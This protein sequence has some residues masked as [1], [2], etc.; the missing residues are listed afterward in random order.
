[1]SRIV[2][3]LAVAALLLLLVGLAIAWLGGAFHEKVDDAAG[4][5]R[6]A[7]APRAVGAAVLSDVRLLRVPRVEQAVGS[8][9]AVHETD[10]ASRVLAAVLEIV[11]RAGDAVERGAVVARLDDDALRAR[12]R[13]AE[14][15]LDS[16]RAVLERARTEADRL[17]VLIERGAV[18]KSERDDAETA[19]RTTQAAAERA[20]RALDETSAALAHTTIHAPLSGVVVERHVEP[21]DTVAPGQ[22]ILTI[23][24]PEHMQLVAG[25]RE[26]LARRLRVG[27]PIPVRIDALDLVCEG[28]ISEIVPR[29]DEVS[30]TFDVKVTGPCP[31]GVYSGMFGRLLVPLGE[32]E[33]LV[34]PA[35]AVREIGQLRLVDVAEG[36]V[37]RRRA[38]RLGRVFGDEVEVLAGLRAGERVVLVQ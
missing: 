9:R 7:A 15:E 28:T 4:A 26:S 25:V 24:D 22:R 27:A 1:M 35:S 33:V 38:V 17:G 18:S 21:G 10:V 14:A 23:Y 6:G 30:R 37:L 3:R 36:G 2:L 13:Q 11:V 20:Q 8:V 5:P 32:E 16:A 31:P 12:V 19:V 34:A 29:A